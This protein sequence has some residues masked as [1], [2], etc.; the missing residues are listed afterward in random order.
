MKLSLKIAL[1]I[2]TPFMI[3]FLSSSCKKNENSEHGYR[4]G[5]MIK[6]KKWR[7]QAEGYAHHK[8]NFPDSI[9]VDYM[10]ATEDES[11]YDVLLKIIDSEKWKKRT[12]K[13][14]Y[15]NLL[16]VHLRLGD[17]LE[18]SPFTVK[19]HLSRY[20]LENGNSYIRPLS[21]YERVLKKL[22]P[23]IS[24]V[25]L[26][27]GFHLPEKS[28]QKSLKFLKKINDFFTSKGFKTSPPRI[29][30][31]ADQDFLLMSNATHFIP[32]G[33]GF[34]WF[35]ANMVKLKGGTVYE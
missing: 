16:V 10:D 24:E 7:E 12:P 11:N 8:K 25:L 2:L 15:K 5:D 33:G 28:F 13:L 19:E 3:F 17:V 34:S 26:I 32:S 1:I 22:P 27:T 20:I 23:K 6:G 30:N 9:A 4:L 14:D 29:D 18:N 31:P 21:Y 35:V